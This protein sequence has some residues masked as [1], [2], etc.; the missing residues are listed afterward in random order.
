MWGVLKMASIERTAYPKLKINISQKELN[1]NYNL[2]LPEIE[3]A[4]SSVKSEDFVISY[5]THLKCFQN[6]GY[7][8]SEDEI[9]NVIV[10]HI[11]NQLNVKKTIDNIKYKRKGTLYKHHVLIRKY[12]KI[13][14]YDNNAEKLLIDTV[15]KNSYTMDN[16]ADLI[17]SAIDILVKNHYELPAYSHIDRLT[18]EIR[19]KV[20]N[21]IF[22]STLRE[23]SDGAKKSLD[24]ILEVDRRT[25]T[26]HVKMGHKTLFTN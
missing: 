11:T 12:L 23:I 2:L 17:N 19:A 5:L 6:L 8:P 13:N 3:H 16:P 21:E 20:L 14:K 15:K 25:S 7:F 24:S 18:L 26:I 9:P 22:E 1:K 4:Y 10:K